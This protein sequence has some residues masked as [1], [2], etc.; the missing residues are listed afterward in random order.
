MDK[1]LAQDFLLK[2]NIIKRPNPTKQAV[3]AQVPLLLNPFLKY[4]G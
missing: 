3:L 4:L 2:G 1:K